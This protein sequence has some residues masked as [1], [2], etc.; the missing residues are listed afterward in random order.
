LIPLSSR[1]IGGV[2]AGAARKIEGR[3]SPKAEA[4]LS[5][6][7]N[8]Q[9]CCAG[10]AGMHGC[11]QQEVTPHALNPTYRKSG[12]EQRALLRRQFDRHLLLFGDQFWLAVTNIV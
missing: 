10:P 5:G 6:S 11:M 9:I 2:I 7:S 1:S 4:R 12:V 8:A 3:H